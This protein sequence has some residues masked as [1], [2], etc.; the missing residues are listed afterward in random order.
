VR[1]RRQPGRCRRPDWGTLWRF[2]AAAGATFFGAGAA[3]YANCLKA[4]VEP[5]A[6]ADLSRLR[7]IGSTGSPLATRLP[8]DLG[9][10]CRRWT[11]NATSGSTPISGG[12]DF[13]GAFVGG[14]PRCRWSGRDAVPL[15][16]RGGAGLDECERP[17]RSLVDEVG[18]LVCTRRCRR[19]RCFLGATTDGQR[20]RDS[21]FD[22]YPGVWRH[23]DWIRMVRPGRRRDHR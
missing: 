2:A 16:G 22:M 14:W 10:H 5:M 9:P 23:G 3:F 4:G 12:T 17:G 19:C 8:L 20:Y 11:G 1:L 6:Q 15:P 18:E 7:A 13:A 21:Y